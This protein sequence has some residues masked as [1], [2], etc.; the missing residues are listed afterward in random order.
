MAEIKHFVV[1]GLGTFGTAIARQLAKNRCRV[2][3]LDAERERVES[4]KDCL[5]EAIIGDARD[6]EA[7]KHLPLAEANAVVLGL[8]EDITQSILAALHVKELGARRVIAKGVTDDHGKILRALGVDR[9]VFPERELAEELADR[10]TWPNVLDYLPIDPE[11]SL[12]EISVP[13]SFGGKTLQ[14]LSLRRDLGILVVGIK[15]AMTG[16]LSMLPDAQFRLQPDQMLL[17]LGK[18]PNLDRLRELR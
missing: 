6:R 12:A 3:G 11:Y 15:D 5:Y 8:G 17:V 18:Q 2:T 16:A 7:L 4:L 13:D 10:L 14:Q 1:I 9:V